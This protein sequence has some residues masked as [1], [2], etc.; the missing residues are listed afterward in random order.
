[1]LALVTFFFLVGSALAA[2]SSSALRATAANESQAGEF[3]AA[4]AG[5]ELGIW[6]Q[7]QGRSGNPPDQTIN[8]LN[9]STTVTTSGG[10][11]CPAAPWPVWL[12]GLE[13]GVVSSA[14]GGLFD[15][16]TVTSGG[17]ITADSAVKRTGGYSLKLERTTMSGSTYVQRPVSGSTLVLRF[18]VRLASLTMAQGGTHLVWIPQANGD[19]VRFEFTTSSNKFFLWWNGGNYAYS[20]VVV[21]AGAW[22]VIDLKVDLRA[23]PHILDW[24]VNGITQTRITKAASPTTV[25]SLLFG[26]NYGLDPAFTAHYDDI[27]VSQTV[28]DY[29][30][31]HDRVLL[32][33]PTGMGVHSSPA[34]FQNND[35]T[36]IGALTYTRL[37]DVPISSAS[38]YVQQT[39]EAG[40]GY[41]E[42]TYEDTTETCILGAEAVLA[43]RSATNTANNGKTSMFVGSAETTVYSGDM[44]ETVQFYK[45]ALVDPAGAGRSCGVDPCP[46]GGWTQ[47]NLNALVGR[48]GYSTDANPDPFWDSLLIEYAVATGGAYGAT[49]TVVGSA[50]ASTITTTYPDPGPDKPTLATWT[51]TR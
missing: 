34:S 1:M 45:S 16:V 51:T 9:V 33:R 15:S 38:E 27:V 30:M 4:D 21:A 13:H 40:T 10:S 32:L 25:T 49:I 24:R 43:Y 22:Y 46:V 20:T 48:I 2:H 17:N 14:G 3:H 37:D 19:Y 29:P 41:V 36:S 28:T 26:T 47:A 50:G 39:T 31:G 5:T 23:N 7:R 18:A 35:G 6:W 42:V 12:T 44:S 8:G 11:S